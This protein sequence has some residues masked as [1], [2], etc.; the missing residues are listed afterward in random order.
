MPSSKVNNRED[1]W[2]SIVGE[3][4]SLTGESFNKMVS[5]QIRNY[6]IMFIRQSMLPN[7][8]H[9]TYNVGKKKPGPFRSS[10]YYSIE[11]YSIEVSKRKKTS[12][13]TVLT[14]DSDE[15][16]I[17][18][19]N[20][21][22]IFTLSNFSRYQIEYLINRS[23]KEILC[24]W[25]D[26]IIKI[27]DGKYNNKNDKNN[28]LFSTWLETDKELDYSVSKYI[29][30]NVFNHNSEL[31]YFKDHGK[32]GSVK[33]R[34]DGKKYPIMPQ[35]KFNVTPAWQTSFVGKLTKLIASTIKDNYSD[36]NYEEDEEV[37]HPHVKYVSKYMAIIINNFLKVIGRKIGIRMFYN[38]SAIIGDTVFPAI[39]WDMTANI[40]EERR[41]GTG[42]CLMM[43][44]MKEYA[45]MKIK[46]KKRAP[47]KKTK[48]VK[49]TRNRVKS[50][51]KVTLNV[52]E[53]DEEYESFS[54]SESSDSDNSKERKNS[55]IKKKQ[56]CSKKTSIRL[57][58]KKTTGKNK[59]I[60]VYKSDQAENEES[61]DDSELSDSVD[62]DT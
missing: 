12:K 59:L 28:P 30:I 15:K 55:K 48:D 40:G 6:A 25:K 54:E 44:T 11:D 43:D 19:I 49:G 8:S 57:K 18:I 51:T 1:S 7:K 32:K 58:T 24:V 33:K 3:F 61:D 9:L 39:L 26:I 36:E 46:I 35:K 5:E 21:K 60:E 23:I 22:D 45:E 56:A 31:K 20:K 50:R 38:R 16:E 29:A 17:I 47:V 52:Q 4:D 34:K 42:I 37:S 41:G 13:R 53:S 14:E 2:K 10:N 62:S 27:D